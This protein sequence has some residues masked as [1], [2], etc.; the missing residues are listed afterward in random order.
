MVVP[1]D[2]INAICES[3]VNESY[4]EYVIE[5]NKKVHD[6]YCHY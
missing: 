5:L 2:L 6:Y 4:L 3:E 1:P